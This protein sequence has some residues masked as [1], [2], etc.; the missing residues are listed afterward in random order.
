MEPEISDSVSQGVALS[1]ALLISWL[2]LFDRI[3]VTAVH[4]M[5]W[6]TFELDPQTPL[7]YKGL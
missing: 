1:D 6:G 4:E 3:L 2:N 7:A 5:S